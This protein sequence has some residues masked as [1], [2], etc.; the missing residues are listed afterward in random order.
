MH[1]NF[2]GRPFDVDS[3]TLHIKDGQIKNIPLK[4]VIENTV[5]IDT[6]IM[7]EPTI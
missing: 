1:I 2:D 3:Q 7:N 5:Q 6:S 4:L